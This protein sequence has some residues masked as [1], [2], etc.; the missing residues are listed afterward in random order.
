MTHRGI[1]LAA[2]LGLALVPTKAAAAS[3]V[4][5]FALVAA[6]NDGGSDRPRL[7]Y[8]LSDA[9]R[10]ARVIVELGGVSPDHAILLNEPRLKEMEDAIDLLEG[11]VVQAARA[12]NR[13][14]RTE[15][16]VYYSGP[17]TAA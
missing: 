2:L 9:E 10:F 16:L 8:A 1:A 6:A 13:G 5:R 17:A 7:K 11:H 4:Q 12:G 14:G 15:V 3:G